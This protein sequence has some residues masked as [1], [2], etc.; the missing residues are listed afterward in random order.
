[1]ALPT[2][3][4][5]QP[6]IYAS[7]QAPNATN[8]QVL[9]TYDEYGKWIPPIG[10]SSPANPVTILPAPTG[11]AGGAGSVGGKEVPT[12]TSTANVAGIPAH[13]LALGALAIVAYFLLRGE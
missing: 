10:Y 9:G 13:Y 7:P 2:A 8:P 6:P 3:D 11:G 5:G 4:N 1:M 12:G